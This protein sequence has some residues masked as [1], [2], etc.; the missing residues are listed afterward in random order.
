MVSSRSLESALLARKQSVDSRG[1]GSLKEPGVLSP[2]ANIENQ[3]IQI[4]IAQ[5]WPQY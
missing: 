3:Q 2:E 5:Y 4:L 1:S